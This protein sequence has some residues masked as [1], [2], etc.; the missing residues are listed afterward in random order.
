MGMKFAENKEVIRS[1]FNK[2]DIESISCNET[3][4]SQDVE[5]VKELLKKN[6]AV[7]VSHYY[8]SD[9]V[10]ELTEKTGGIVADSLD[11]TKFCNTHSASTLLV[12]GVKF[13]AE[14]AKILNP[15]KEVIAIDLEATCSLD[16]LCPASDLEKL[17]KKNPE[18]TVVVYINTSAEVK[19]L[20]DWVVTS[21]IAE[22]IIEHIS[23][24]SILWA[25]D[26]HLGSYLQQKTKADML[27]WDGACV[28]HEGFK[29]E[30]ILK[31]KEVYPNAALISH[32]ESPESILQISDFIGSTSQLIKAVETMPNQQF[33]VAT[34]RGVFYKMKKVSPNKELI[35]APTAGHSAECF[36]CARCPWMAMNSVSKI[37]EILK[38]PSAR[39]KNKIFLED[40]VIE[41]AKIPLN[42]MI[43]FSQ[44][45]N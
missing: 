1:S 11:M 10:Q 16:L 9:A 26:K 45:L 20:A 38:N 21:S 34:E 5:E 33:I 19:A 24:K 13:M 3:L 18:K 32:P 14:T 2:I 4:T 25:P 22:Q 12:S 42:R 44:T 29:L 37:K 15:E 31:L 35:Q 39:N 7:L 28:V 17:I 6:N 27:I 8:T 23:D 40:S 43:D 30:E 41:K 36:S